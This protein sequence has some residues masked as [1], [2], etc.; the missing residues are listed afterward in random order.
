MLHVS[1]KY[2]WVHTRALKRASHSTPTHIP[3]LPAVLP[4]PLPPEQCR[5]MTLPDIARFYKEHYLAEVRPLLQ[6]LNADND[7]AA[8]GMAAERRHEPGGT[9]ATHAANPSHQWGSGQSSS[10][11]VL[12]AAL[13]RH[14]GAAEVKIEVLDGGAAAA[15]APSGSGASV[16]DRR[17]AAPAAGPAGGRQVAGGVPDGMQPSG[18]SAA[19]RTAAARLSSNDAAAALD[20]LK[21]ELFVFIQNLD[22][23]NPE[24]LMKCVLLRV[25]RCTLPGVFPCVCWHL[26]D[27]QFRAAFHVYSRRNALY[28]NCAGSGPFLL[29]QAAALQSRGPAWRGA[30]CCAGGP[31]PGGRAGGCRP[32]PRAAVRGPSV[33]PRRL[34]PSDGSGS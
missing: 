27:R 21:R 24:G 32:E 3:V 1:Y 18:A 28:T 29:L 4:L 2:T 9:A 20:V 8:D 30:G 5:A 7:G 13:C 10:A 31:L 6:A 22:M 15:A 34:G 19:W 33:V 26:L 17:A 16:A 11:A 12:L 25:F 14:D 23:E